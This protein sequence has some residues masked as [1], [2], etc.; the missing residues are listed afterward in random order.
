MRLHLCF[1]IF[2]STILPTHSAQ[3]DDSPVKWFFEVTRDSGAGYKFIA[4]GTIHDG[5][6]IYSQYLQEGGPIP[7]SICFNTNTAMPVG[8][9]TEQ[10]NKHTFYSD[11]YECEIS[12]FSGSV[13]F[14]RGFTPNGSVQEVTGYMEYLAC[15][16]FT[17]VP[18][19][20]SFRVSYR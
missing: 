13:V 7:T 5:W 17:C 14:E 19:R 8:K 2:F 11:L 4:K 9:A 15:N 6:H 16:D 3:R 12:W 18:A 10:G 20:V 1:L